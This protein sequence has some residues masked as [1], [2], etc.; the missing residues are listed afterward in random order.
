[1]EKQKKIAELEVILKSKQEA[2]IDVKN[3]QITIIKEPD[4]KTQS[5]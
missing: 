5:R 3:F 4:A 1:M 2:L